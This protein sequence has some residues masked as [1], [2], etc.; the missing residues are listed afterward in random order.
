[1][2]RD[3]EERREFLES[4][5]H[6]LVN[7]NQ[8]VFLDEAQKDR[9]ASRRRRSWARRGKGAFRD[10]YFNGTRNKRYT[11]IAACDIDGFIINAC[12]IVPQ[13][14]SN[15][16]MDETHG[17]V[18]RERFKLW[19]EEKLVPI[20]G[21]FSRSEPRSIVIMDNASIHHGEEIKEIIEAAGAKLIYT[22]P[23][24][25]DLNPIELMFG[26]YK[27]ALKRFSKY[28]SWSE[29]HYFSLQSVDP[30]KARKFFRHSKVPGCEHF[31]E[32]DLKEKDNEDAAA[33]AVAMTVASLIVN[34][35]LK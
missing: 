3:E 15:D 10:A 20:L 7:P 1:L 12:Q 31:P 5:E 11:L 13:Q 2:Q 33:I 16:D 19:V 30:L 8:L 17:T 23:Y 22:A 24:S 32:F 6:F 26:E 9:N 4:I 34:G 18:D 28:H 25:P 27:K 21:N 35:K 14:T 29:S